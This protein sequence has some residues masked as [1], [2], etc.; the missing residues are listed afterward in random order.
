VLDVYSCAS[1]AKINE[2]KSEL[3]LAGPARY[4]RHLWE[5]IPAKIVDESTRYL[6]VQIGVKPTTDRLWETASTK[7]R[8]TL[9]SWATRDITLLGRV[10]VLKTLA[11]SQ[12]WHVASVC[13]APASIIKS[14]Q[15]QAW[16]FLWKGSS[17][18]AVTRR[19]CLAPRE[20]GGL[21]MI[22]IK[23]TIQSLHL[24]WL[25]KLY[26]PPILPWKA[27][28]LHSF[29]RSPF[30]RTWNLGPLD[31][32]AVKYNSRNDLMPKRLRF[33]EG[34]LHSLSNLNAIK[35]PPVTRAEVLMEPL[36]YN[37]LLVADG[38]PLA[39]A[40]L[41]RLAQARYTHISHV[42][43]D[44]SLTW[45][46]LDDPG[47]QQLLENRILPHIPPHWTALLSTEPTGSLNM[48]DS[49][50]SLSSAGS[51][52]T[53]AP[54]DRISVLQT[55]RLI[56]T[57]LSDITVQGCTSA[58]SKADQYD[59]TPSLLTR[60]SPL[61]DGWV[62]HWPSV[63]R[64]VWHKWRDRKINDKLWLILH[65]GLRLGKSIRHYTDS[66]GNCPCK[67]AVENSTHLF[68]SCSIAAS[69]WRRALTLFRD[70][71]GSTSWPLINVRSIFFGQFRPKGTLHRHFW[72]IVHAELLYSI[73]LCR[74]RSIFDH[75]PY[76]EATIWALFVTRLRRSLRVAARSDKD[77][78]SIL[79][80]I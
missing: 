56:P 68:I 55:A 74:C 78:F 2:A 43:D 36:F 20:L 77:M 66:D 73:W 61:L 60:W 4:S 75:D 54:Y 47:L 31:M 79:D 32:T 30:C 69:L 29:Q 59:P 62:P 71:S 9:S 67:R 72:L 42:W 40:Q 8:S 65:D 63:F 13:P 76:S 27:L 50:A 1:C 44:F 80:K 5:N 51:S 28:A 53:R 12:L 11:S 16:S 25:K 45:A 26:G 34:A 41:L 39:D 22:D 18:G 52:A 7:Y 35:L 24:Q 58:L 38:S 23:H 15:D 33:W 70:A 48:D 46:D 37:P 10:T 19:V 21:G 3:I 64:W 57:L 17:R 6:G 14:L 49:D